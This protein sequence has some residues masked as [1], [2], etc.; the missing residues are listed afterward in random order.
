M[1]EIHRYRKLLEIGDLVQIRQREL[2]K[3]SKSLNVTLAKATDRFFI[4]FWILF[5]YIFD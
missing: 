2:N 4:L 5:T 3:L 1:F